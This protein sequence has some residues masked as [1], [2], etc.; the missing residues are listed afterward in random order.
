[1][2]II[3]FRRFSTTGG[4]WRQVHGAARPAQ[5]SPNE[6]EDKALGD[7][8]SAS[9]PQLQQKKEASTF[10]SVVD[11]SAE[12]CDQMIGNLKQAKNKVL[13]RI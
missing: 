10:Q 12:A 3:T 7:A 4:M 13:Y 5:A 9:A 1:M 2:R 8:P 6:E 11:S